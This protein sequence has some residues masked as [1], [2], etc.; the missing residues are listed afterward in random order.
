MPIASKRSSNHQ[1]IR[2]LQPK[3]SRDPQ[4]DDGYDDYVY[5]PYYP[6]ATS[7]NAHPYADE[8]DQYEERPVQRYTNPSA[9]SLV[10]Q[11]RG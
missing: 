2:R 11:P 10:Q 1:T 9:N 8:P 7:E 6:Q 5:Y 4:D 3:Q